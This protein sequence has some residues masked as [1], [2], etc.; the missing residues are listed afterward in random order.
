MIREDIH[1]ALAMGEKALRVRP[2]TAK[3]EALRGASHLLQVQIAG[4]HRVRRGAA[5][6]AAEHLAKA[7]QKNGSLRRKYQTLFHRAQRPVEAGRNL[8]S[9]ERRSLDFPFWCSHK[10]LS[11]CTV[12]PPKGNTRREA[13]VLFSE[14]LLGPFTTR[15]NRNPRE[16][17][18]W[19][20]GARF[21]FADARGQRPFFAMAPVQGDKTTQALAEVAKEIADIVGLRP[22]RAEELAQAKDNLTLTLP[23]RWKTDEA[24]LRSLF[25]VVQFGLPWDYPATSAT[26]IRTQSLEAVREVVA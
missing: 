23:G 26:R 12:F 24:V 11:T 7:L 20:Y 9:Q 5:K 4:D 17:K 8:A 3:A 1:Q 15:R 2:G 18:H 16:E 10:R 14:A 6:K 21:V 13:L 19:S 22:V 25:E